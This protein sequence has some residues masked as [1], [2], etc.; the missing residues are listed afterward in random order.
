MSWSDS[1]YHQALA[2]RASETCLQLSLDLTILFIGR[3]KEKQLCAEP[4]VNKHD[5]SN[6]NICTDPAATQWLLCR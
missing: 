2:L 4:C 3:N 6:I 1:W 5:E